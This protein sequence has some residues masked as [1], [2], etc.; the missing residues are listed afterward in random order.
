MVTKKVKSVDGGGQTEYRALLEKVTKKFDEIYA[1]NR[2]RLSCGRG[3]SSC[4]VANLTVFE[5]EREN[6][7]NFI[8]S[9]DGLK[10]ELL[11]IE[12]ADV[13]SSQKCSFLDGAGGCSI[14]EARPVVCRSHGAPVFVK[15]ETDK[16]HRDVCPL[17]FTD[18]K[19]DQIEAENFINLDLLN[20]VLVLVNKKFGG[21]GVRTPL[22][23]SAIF[24]S[25][26]DGQDSK[27]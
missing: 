3:C 10:A 26:D 25:I 27:S 14:Y 7:R 21:K 4:C 13:H 23:A 15:T 22:K 16:S 18:L 6:I 8:S 20:Q 24:N 1:R 5:V 11:R 17:N 9:H 19:I 12:R 2:D